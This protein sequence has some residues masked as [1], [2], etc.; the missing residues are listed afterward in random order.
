M[1]PST[2]PVATLGPQDS[3]VRVTPATVATTASSTGLPV[4]TT[5][6]NTG[7]QLRVIRIPAARPSTL[8]PRIQPRLP[9][10]VGLSSVSSTLNSVNSLEHTHHPSDQVLHTSVSALRSGG[11]ATS[12]S[13]STATVET[14]A[15]NRQQPL[16]SS[17]VQPIRDN[18]IIVISSQ[19]YVDS[20]TH[21]S[22]ATEAV[23]I[24]IIFFT[25]VFN[26]RFL[27]A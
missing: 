25:I 24:K 12:T 20:P 16:I 11:S 4:I 13:P 26:L 19:Q 18:G 2:S 3:A 7:T 14:V 8:L 27:L 10:T 9:V 17:T 15:S 5:R 23:S 1:E 21:N 22:H 6:G